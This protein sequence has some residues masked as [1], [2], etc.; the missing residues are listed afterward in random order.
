MAL[1]R[2][3]RDSDQAIFDEEATDTQHALS[4][5][6]AKLKVKLA[7]KGQ[8]APDYM[9]GIIPTNQLVLGGGVLDI[10]VFKVPLSN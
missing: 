7:L 4:L 5:F 6:G 9:M 1:Y 2:L 10:E 3:R 8:A